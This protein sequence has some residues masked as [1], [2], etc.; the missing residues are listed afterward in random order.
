MQGCKECQEEVGR[1]KFGKT[2]SSA[3][4]AAI[5]FCAVPF[6]LYAQDPALQI[7]QYPIR[8]HY[9][10]LV[11]YNNDD[12]EEEGKE[13]GEKM[14]KLGGKRRYNEDM[15][16]EVSEGMGVGGRNGR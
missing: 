4:D 2:L 7:S 15:K 12:A 13:R 11:E 8:Q 14:G 3:Y 9:V 16:V 10:A 5:P 1:D 6:H